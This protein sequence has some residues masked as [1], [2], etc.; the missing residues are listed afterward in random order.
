MRHLQGLGH[1]NPGPRTKRTGESTLKMKVFV[2]VYT[3]T[4]EGKN[5]KILKF[6]IKPDCTIIIEGS[7]KPK[8]ENIK[9]DE[10]LYIKQG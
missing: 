2:E 6:E 5:G 9:K 3:Q 4:D 7:Q 1:F 10:P 8:P